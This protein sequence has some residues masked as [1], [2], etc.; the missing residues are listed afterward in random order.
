MSENRPIWQAVAA[1]LWRHKQLGQSAA[2]LR[3]GQVMIVSPEEIM[4]DEDAASH[5]SPHGGATQ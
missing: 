4:I 2:V 5:A 3:D 1:A